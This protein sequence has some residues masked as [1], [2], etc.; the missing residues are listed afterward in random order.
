MVG[1]SG[2]VA[3]TFWVVTLSSVTGQI[4]L[5]RFP[6]AT[7]GVIEFLSRKAAVRDGPPGAAGHHVQDN[8]LRRLPNR[9]RGAQLHREETGPWPRIRQNPDSWKRSGQQQRQHQRCQRRRRMRQAMSARPAPRPDHRIQLCRVD[10]PGRA[11]VAPQFFAFRRKLCRLW[12]SLCCSAGS[13]ANIA[14]PTR[15]GTFPV[16]D[17][18]FELQGLTKWLTKP[19]HKYLGVRRKRRYPKSLIGDVVRGHTPPQP[20][21]QLLFPFPQLQK[22]SPKQSRSGSDLASIGKPCAQ[23]MPTSN[24]RLPQRRYGPPCVMAPKPRTVLKVTPV[25]KSVLI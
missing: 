10:G 18:S 24:K 9:Q 22:T 20:A 19:G 23:A 1:T 21:S 4:Q 2:T 3:L 8:D 14:E 7:G 15:V 11:P 12:T 25:G 16:P 17:E 13:V 6:S 5:R